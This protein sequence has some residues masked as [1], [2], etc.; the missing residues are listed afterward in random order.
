M[1]AK[2]VHSP[3]SVGEDDDGSSSVEEKPQKAPTVVEKPNLRDRIAL[4]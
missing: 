3:I 2:S 1:F 4:S